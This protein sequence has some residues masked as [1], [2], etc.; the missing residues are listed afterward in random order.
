M[1]EQFLRPQY[2][3]ILVNP[4]AH[5][6]SQH[7]TPNQIT[8]FSGL[9][10]LLVLPALVLNQVYL[11]IG[12]LLLSGYCDTL[13]GTLARLRHYSS[14]WGSVL[15]IITDRVVE[16]SVVFALWAV[17]PNQRG[18]GCLLMMASMLICITSF[19]VVGIFNP[20]DSEKSFHYSPGLMERAEAFAFFIAMMIWPNAFFILALVFSLLVIL[21]AVLR[22][23]AFH[24]LQKDRR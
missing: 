24:R 23:T 2:Q 14:D 21:T 11:A 20:N 10:G 19:L 6:L 3:R 7:V 8:L 15:D 17:A 9:L 5:V 1:I 22:V 4:I 12:L 16:P 13:D 18:L